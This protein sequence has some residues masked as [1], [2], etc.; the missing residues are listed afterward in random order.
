MSFWDTFENIFQDS[1]TVK[2]L[3]GATLGGQV[4]S[5]GYCSGTCRPSH[6]PPRVPFPFHASIARIATPTSFDTHQLH[7]FSFLRRD[8]CQVIA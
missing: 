1:S 6:Q 2:G 4:A 8:E 3:F 7:L 5:R